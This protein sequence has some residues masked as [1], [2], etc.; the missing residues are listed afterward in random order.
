MEPVRQESNP[1]KGQRVRALYTLLLRMAAPLFWWQLW[2]RSR[3]E[4]GKWQILGRERFGR[5]RAPYTQQAVWVHAVSLG[6]T[7]AARPLIDA[8]LESGH[9][10]LL[11]HT[12]ATAWTEARRAHAASIESGKLIQQWLPYDFPG[13]V[14]RFFRA[15]RP[16]VGLL[17]EREVWPNLVH[18]ARQSA[19]PLVLVSAR[20]SE[21]SQRQ[22]QR[23]D[24]LMR[25]AFG[26]LEEV[27]A[28]TADDARRLL[29]C[30][31]RQVQVVGNLKFDVRVSPELVARGQAWA[32]QLGRPV[33]CIA[34]TR[35]GEEALFIAAVT[36][37]LQTRAPEMGRVLFL[38]VP[39]HPQRFDEVARMLG[40]SGMS[41]VRRSG[42]GEQ[43]AAGD[44]TWV[45]GDSVGEMAAYYA[46]SQ[47]AIIGG[48]FL[49]FGGQNL[50]E[51]CAAGVPVI[52][53]PYTRNFA[54]A[55]E[56][57]VAAGAAEQVADPSAAVQLAVKWLD[58]NQL[59]LQRAQ[60]AR[61]FVEAN[62][63]AT[64]RVMGALS[65]WL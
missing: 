7:R 28:Q 9:T 15:W 42:W 43:A 6:E 44:A 36:E 24:R 10:V 61:T 32:R 27:L 52:V 4:G 3:R 50:V 39:R 56:D 34:S 51:A 47:V 58:N 8:L 53:G 64:A 55:V 25:P 30:G 48:S 40:T 37:L 22:M 5:Y 13:S 12:T 17:I 20:L 54:Q 62:Q 16:R 46:A 18:A 57:A 63:G 38:L 49:D 21:K 11:T 19:V 35:E 60:A 29:A 41:Y 14:R 33:V 26:A 1:A 59:R 65:P 2:R 23:F 31:A 45:L